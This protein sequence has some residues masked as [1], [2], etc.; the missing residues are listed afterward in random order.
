MYLAAVLE[1]LAAEILELAGN[2][3]RNPCNLQLAVRNDEGLNKL[4]KHLSCSK[5][6]FTFR[7][8]AVQEGCQISV[9][10]LQIHYPQPVFLNTTTP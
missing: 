4:L 8:N 6:V 3:A 2:A 5:G 1:Y 9:R 10:A 7:P